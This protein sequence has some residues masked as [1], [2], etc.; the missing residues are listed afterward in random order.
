[1]T[2]DR[3]H[4]LDTNILSA[5]A[6][7]PHGRALGRLQALGAE[8]ICTSVIVACEIRFGLAK[9]ASAALTERLSTMLA[10]LEILPLLPQMQEHYAEIR[11]H[12]EKAGLPIGPNDLLIAAQA[13][14][15]GLTVVT[16][17]V[18]EFS[19]VPG[20]LVE[21]WLESG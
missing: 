2:G 20:L 11:V 16:D 7:D 4:L 6:K 19:R 10:A 3:T 13:R 15:L 18:G 14:S 21:N 17:Y 9:R 8:R 1:M 12:L 5:L